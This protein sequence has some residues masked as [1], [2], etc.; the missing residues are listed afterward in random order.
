MLVYVLN[1]KY[2]TNGVQETLKKLKRFGSYEGYD[3]TEQISD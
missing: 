1:S 3:G 2:L